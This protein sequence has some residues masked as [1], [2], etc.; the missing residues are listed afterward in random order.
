[1]VIMRLRERPEGAFADVD[2]DAIIETTT[3]IQVIRVP[4]G[5]DSG[6]SALILRIDLPDGRVVA[7][8]TTAKLFL[9]VADAIREL[10]QTQH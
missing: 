6:A 9:D 4:K 8:K 7:A 10:E 3:P 1:M 2:R 5:M